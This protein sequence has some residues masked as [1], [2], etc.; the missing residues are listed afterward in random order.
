MRNFVA[1]ILL[2]LGAQVSAAPIAKNQCNNWSVSSLQHI[3]EQRATFASNDQVTLKWDA[4]DSDVEFISTV[5]LF[6]ANNNEFLHTQYRS[7]PGVNAANGEVSFTLTVPL[8]LQREGEYYLEVYG[9]TPGADSDCS[10]Q[11]VP[12]ELTPDPTGDFSICDL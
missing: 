6:S 10:L 12:F 7:Y 8:C 5:A 11:T 3:G 2:A 4:H 1:C 9:S